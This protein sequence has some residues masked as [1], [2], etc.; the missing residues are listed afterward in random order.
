MSKKTR[1][2]P[3]ALN[4]IDHFPVHATRPRPITD[5]PQGGFVDGYDNDVTARTMPVEGVPR[6]AEIVFS[7]LAEA[8]QAEH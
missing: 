1:F 8:N 4:P 7:N 6:D 2:A 3:A 5:L